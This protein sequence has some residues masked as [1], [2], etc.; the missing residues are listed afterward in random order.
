MSFTLTGGS[1]LTKPTKLTATTATVLYAAEKRTVILSIIAVEVAGATPALTL[2]LFDGT[3]AYRLRNAF[4]MAAKETFI[5]NEPITLNSG[6]S[7]RATAS[8][9]D[10]IECFATFMSPDATALGTWNGPQG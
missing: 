7:L 4:A 1:I 5:F 9:A 10:Q 3:T 2:D 6:W 8:A